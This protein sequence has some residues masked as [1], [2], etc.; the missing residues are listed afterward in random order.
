M[1]FFN[2]SKMPLLVLAL[3]PFSSFSMT[4]IHHHIPPFAT[5]RREDSQLT[6]DWSLLQPTKSVTGRDAREMIHHA[7]AAVLTLLTG[8]M[9]H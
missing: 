5:G 8:I 4:S 1:E 6:V 3:L 9:W 2:L 7:D